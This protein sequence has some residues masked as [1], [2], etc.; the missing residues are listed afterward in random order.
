MKG[1]NLHKLYCITYQAFSAI[2]SPITPT[3]IIVISA[4]IISLSLKLSASESQSCQK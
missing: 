3:P 2:A 1:L 4:S